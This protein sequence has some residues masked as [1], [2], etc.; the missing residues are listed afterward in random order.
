MKSNYNSVDMRNHPG[1]Y[2]K[3]YIHMLQAKETISLLSSHRAEPF[4]KHSRFEFVHI[5]Q[6]MFICGFTGCSQTDMI[7]QLSDEIMG[8]K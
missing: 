1:Q 4:K 2:L 8:C 6:I 7:N 3:Y 5:I